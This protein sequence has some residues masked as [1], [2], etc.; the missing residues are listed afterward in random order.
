MKKKEVDYPALKKTV[1]LAI[2]F[3]D[4]VIDKNA[5]PIKEIE[6]MTKKTR[7]VGLGV[8]GFADMLLM[9]GIPYNSQNGIDT[10]KKV[11][12]FVS[13]SAK[14]ASSELAQ[15][16]GNFPLYGESVFRKTNQPMRNATVTTI[17]PTGTISIICGTS[18]GV[19]PVF[20]GLI[21]PQCNG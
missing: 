14:Q 2:H 10:A 15:I 11:M 6:A 13:D 7:K 21:Y 17:A 5:Y 12:K 18:S 19:E 1:E 16:R 20:A 8:M 4:N 3:L 9:L